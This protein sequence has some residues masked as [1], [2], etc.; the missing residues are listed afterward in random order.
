MEKKLTAQGPNDRKSYTVTLPIEWVKKQNLDK[1]RLVN[2]EI[3]ANKVI[4][5]ATGSNESSHTIHIDDFKDSIIKILQGVYRI[6]IDTLQIHFSNAEVMDHLLEISEQR[7]IGYEVIEHNVDSIVI[8]DITKESGESF[9]NVLRRV[10]RLL[11]ELSGAANVIQV[12]SIDKNIKKL[13]NY[14]QRIIIKEGHSEHKKVSLYYL[15]LDRLEKIADELK[16]IR[17]IKLQNKTDSDY[18][19]NLINYLKQAYSLFYKFDSHLYNQMQAESNKT[20]MAVINS[21]SSGKLSM[22]IYAL[23]R[24]M[25]SLYGDIYCIKGI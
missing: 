22:H 23:S 2:L 8:K 12:R 21:K 10:F 17:I 11:I 7:L 15:L 1:K 6:G 14:A 19:D 25:N 13:I 5:S 16:W 24:L 20:R 9:D 18:L 4:I 3:L